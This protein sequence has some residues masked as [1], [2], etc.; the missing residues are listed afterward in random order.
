[1][2]KSIFEGLGGGF[3]IGIGGAVFLACVENRYIGAVCFT[4]ALLSICLM[5]MQLFTG[6]VGTVVEHH[7]K[8]DL[9]SLLGCLIGNTAGT[10]FSALMLRVIRPTAAAHAIAMVEKKLDA[11][12]LSVFLAAVFCGILMHT[13]VWC[14]KEKNTPS[15]IFFCVPVFILAG[16][17]HSIADMMYFFTAM[18]INV[19]SLIFII[20]VLIGNSVGGALMPLLSKIAKS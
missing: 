3:Y 20:V 19:Q 14:F 2:K 18:S 1:M 11:S 8:G 12:L 6:K 5:G 4:V 17:E 9:L 15:A 10:F 16:F 13:A 7:T